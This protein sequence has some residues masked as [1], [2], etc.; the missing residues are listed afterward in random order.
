MQHD[1][2]AEEQTHGDGATKVN[3]QQHFGV[4]FG[5]SKVVIFIADS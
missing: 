2:F 4:A 3:A 1:A 5:G